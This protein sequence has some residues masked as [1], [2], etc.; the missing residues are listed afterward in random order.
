MLL[1]VLI[2]QSKP[3]IFHRYEISIWR[4]ADMLTKISLPQN[5][6]FELTSILKVGHDFTE[7]NGCTIKE[8][9]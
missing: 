9:K 8:K 6:V 4:A 5:I 3:T 1:D 7:E 2:N